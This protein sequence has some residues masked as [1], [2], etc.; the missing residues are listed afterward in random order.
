VTAFDKESRVNLLRVLLEA[1]LWALRQTPQSSDSDN[2]KDLVQLGEEL[3][4]RLKGSVLL[5]SHDTLWKADQF[6]HTTAPRVSRFCR[7]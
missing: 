1:R 7:I 4:S 2:D 5:I 6:I 3:L